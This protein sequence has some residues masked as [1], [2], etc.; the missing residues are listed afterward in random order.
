MRLQTALK[1]QLA[2]L[3]RTSVN[4]LARVLGLEDGV[5]RKY[6]METST[7]TMEGFLRICGALQL[8]PLALLVDTES[9]VGAS[10]GHTAL[11]ISALR[12]SKGRRYSRD[13]LA[14][15]HATL[16]ATLNAPGRSVPSLTGIANGLGCTSGTLTQH[17]P[18]LCAAIV[19][20]NYQWSARADKVAI[21]NGELARA[22]TDENRVSLNEVARR[23]HCTVDILKRHAPALCNEVNRRNDPARKRTIFRRRLEDVLLDDEPRSIADCARE[24]QV[25]AVWLRKAYPVLSRAVSDRYRELRRE[26]R[27]Q[28]RQKERQSVIDAAHALYAR[29]IYPSRE[30]IARELGRPAAFFR[31]GENNQALVFARAELGVRRGKRDHERLRV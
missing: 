22:L 23:I 30:R 8:P 17:F 21:I 16:V 11:R 26:R 25:S 10:G 28:R 13:E 14:Q 20:R 3:S 1:S 7:L 31:N 19:A 5:A 6:C 4:E 15:V 18:D 29:G 24:W 27:V 2:S 9:L 12:H